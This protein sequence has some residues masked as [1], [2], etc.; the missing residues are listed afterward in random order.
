MPTVGTFRA[1]Q[2]FADAA[3]DYGKLLSTA[4][5]YRPAFDHPNDPVEFGRAIARVGYATSEDYESLLVS[6]LRSRNL[7]AL[8]PV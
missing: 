6:V 3:D 5:R 2:S 8:D 4:P 1:Y 7:L